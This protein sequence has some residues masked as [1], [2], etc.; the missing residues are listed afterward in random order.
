MK[1]ML[2]LCVRG[3][4]VINLINKYKIILIII[5]LIFVNFLYI[6]LTKIFSQPTMQT[7]SEIVWEQESPMPIETKPL[8]ETIIEPI[9]VPIFVCG[10][11]K[12]P[13]VYYVSQD[14]ILE[15]AI[16]LAGGFEEDADQNILN[17]AQVAS[18]N[19]KIYIPK[20]G[21]KIDKPVNSYENSKEDE[22]SPK[23]CIVNINEDDVTRLK[24]LPGIGDTKATAIINY[25][26]SHGA[27]K[28]IEAIKD[29]SGIGDA[30]YEKLKECITIE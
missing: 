1:N 17:L 16:T 3:D 26:E 13:G 14:T 29:V 27:F 18:A 20:L 15:E 21:E 22:N 25:R 30:T 4:Y 12:K 28:T 23:S 9:T 24:T 19:S 8:E 7:Q 5:L 2:K 6:F 10:A 11:V